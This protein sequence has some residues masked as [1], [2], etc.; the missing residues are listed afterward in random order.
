MKATLRHCLLWILLFNFFVGHAQKDRH[1][2]GILTTILK[3]ENSAKH[4]IKQLD[5][6]HTKFSRHGLANTY[7]DRDVDFDVFHL[8]VNIF[9]DSE[10]YQ[11]D[12][13]K[14]NDSLLA[15][16]IKNY[17]N[18]LISNSPLFVTIAD[19]NKVLN[20]LRQRNTFYQSKKSIS[21]L[22]EELTMSEEYAFKCGYG[23]KTTEKGAIVEAFVENE[24]IDE[25]HKMLQS[26]NIETQ[27]FGVQGFKM[28]EVAHFYIP[29]YIRKTLSH[30]KKRNSI[31]ITCA[32][33]FTGI[34]ERIYSADPQSKQ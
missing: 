19:S 29:K 1:Y 4:F 28:L 17:P 6:L 31:T 27:A 25:L 32:G 14:E 11:I 18:I 9:L 8:R 26:I 12:L 22:I 21:D 30:I 20:F 7:I 16:S 2:L 24:N 23:S 15:K 5:S 13:L 34:L 10:S 3:K 33:C